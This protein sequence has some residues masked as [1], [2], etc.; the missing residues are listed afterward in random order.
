M[1]AHIVEEIRVF[2]DDPYQLDLRLLG[3]M[4]HRGLW[5]PTLI[6]A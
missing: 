6:S 1:L 4:S 5:R 3:R 2:D